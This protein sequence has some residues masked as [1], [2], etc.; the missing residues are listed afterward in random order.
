VAQRYVL[1]TT[2]G[3][4]GVLRSYRE[5]L[6]D[7]QK[8]VVARRREFLAEVR[9]EEFD[10]PLFRGRFYREL[11]DDVIAA[12]EVQ[13]NSIAH[14]L[15]AVAGA[16]T[17]T[18]RGKTAGEVRF[19]K[20]K[21]GDSNQ[22]AWNDAGPQE[23]KIY[24]DFAFDPKNT[25]PLAKVLRATNAA[26]GHSMSAYAVFT[27]LKSADVSPDGS[28][29]G[30]G[31]IAKIAEMRRAYMNCVE[32]L[33]ALSDT[34]YDEI[35]APHWAAVSRQEDPEERAEVEQIIEDAVEIKE[36]P[37]A[38][39]EEQEDEMDADNQEEIAKAVKTA[40]LRWSSSDTVLTPAQSAALKELSSKFFAVE[41]HPTSDSLANAVSRIL[42]TKPTLSDVEL[43][44]VYGVSDGDFW[45][46]YV[47]P[48]DPKGTPARTEAM[49]MVKL[50]TKDLMLDGR[51]RDQ[52]V[53][54]I[55]G[56]WVTA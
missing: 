38:W 55:S 27:K 10:P 34:L 29:G 37:E 44:M 16:G 32:A 35:R 25:K 40:S 1:G 17:A 5:F 9:A 31:Y 21:S 2:G 39:A 3:L 6:L 8:M 24:P 49:K 51:Q 14:H 11:P 15:L 41:A 53:E 36:D 22:W 42:A 52:F 46:L 7:T 56:Q 33:S 45:P 4:E 20:D 47:G 26:L 18:P 30:K 23:R 13:I 28:L 12:L 19:I 43:G 48:L 54:S 50:L